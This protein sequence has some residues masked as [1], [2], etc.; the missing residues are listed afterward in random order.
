VV[1]VIGAVAH[2][3]GRH[4]VRRRTGRHH[5][6][7]CRHST[8]VR[9]TGLVHVTRADIAPS[10]TNELD[11]AEAA[12]V[13]EYESSG[14]DMPPMPMSLPPPAFGSAT[15]FMQMPP[16]TIGASAIAADE[17]APPGL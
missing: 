9:C 5:R 10:H 14:S 15:N 1:R 11:E 3:M 17:L 12:A 13:R 6:C 7:K 4:V 16:P 8:K 2:S